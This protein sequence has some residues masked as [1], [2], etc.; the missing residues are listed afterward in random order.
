MFVKKIERPVCV[1]LMI[2][3]VTG[4]GPLGVAEIIYAVNSYDDVPNCN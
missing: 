3:Q 1:L 2:F 4:R